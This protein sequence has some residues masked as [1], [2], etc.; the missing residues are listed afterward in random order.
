[1]SD[2]RGYLVLIGGAED[3]IDKITIL[4]KVMQ[5]SRNG[6]IAVVPCATSQPLEAVRD[7]KDVFERIGAG[8]VEGLDIRCSADGDRDYYL[9]ILEKSDTIFFTGGDQTRLVDSLYRTKVMDKIRE[10]YGN[11]ATIAGTSAGAAAASDPMI[12]DGDDEGFNKY[13]VKHTKGL[14]FLR[15]ITVDT[16]FLQRER[17]PRLSQFLSSGISSR[18]L[19]INEDTAIVVSPDNRFEV[20]GSGTVTVM[21]AENMKYSSYDEVGKNEP[22]SVDGVEIGF[23][24]EGTVFD[25]EEWR[26]EKEG[27]SVIPEGIK[28]DYAYH[29]ERERYESREREYET[30]NEDSFK[31]RESDNSRRNEYSRDDKK[32]DKKR[33]SE[34]GRGRN[35]KGR[36]HR[37]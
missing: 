23:L 5:L 29:S 1:M 34:R 17:I 2:K 21:N 32:Y 6:N 8:S 30:Q 20:I 25:I 28:H 10:R 11:G 37:R 15:G 14:G 22:V 16:H 26:I 24:A 13:A 9:D 4:R 12:Y 33:P 7:Y 19:G 27:K 3:K 31:E 36:R 35:A 18:A